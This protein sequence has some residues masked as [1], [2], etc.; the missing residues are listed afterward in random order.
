MADIRL[1]SERARFGELFVLRGL[2]ADAAGPRPARPARR[3]RAGRRAAVHRRR[4]RRRDG[5]RH[6]PGVTRRPPRRGR[7]R[8]RRRS[9]R[10]IAANPPLAVQAIKAGPAAGP[11]PRLGGP[12][13]V[14]DDEPRPPVPDRRPPRGRGRVPREAPGEL[15][16][17]ADQ[18]LP[19]LGGIRPTPSSGREPSRKPERI[20]PSSRGVRRTCRPARGLDLGDHRRTRRVGSASTARSACRR[21][22]CGT[23]AR[24]A[25]GSRTSPRRSSTATPGA[26][27]RGCGSARGAPAGRS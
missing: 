24:S 18:W 20:P 21:R 15:P 1:A 19:N 7:H 9:P 26:A 8:R 16:P 12:R 14:G 5:G 4:D 3:P 6:R 22:R 23:T 11:R 2:V 25:R 13:R 10:R 27:R 17:A